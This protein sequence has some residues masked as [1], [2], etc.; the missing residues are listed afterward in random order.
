[1]AILVLLGCRPSAAP[2]ESPS[3]N[4]PAEPLPVA[5]APTPTPVD[6]SATSE[7]TTTPT[8]A[9]VAMAATIPET[10]FAAD[11]IVIGV[12]FD[13]APVTLFADD[14]KQ[15]RHAIA[16]TIARAG[17]PVVPVADLERIEA[18][19]GKGVLELEGGRR[20][21][22]ALTAA[23][24]E[25]RYFRGHRI[26][27]ANATCM[28]GCRLDVHVDTL[29]GKDS[30]LSWRHTGVRA[31]EAPRSWIAA[32]RALRVVD[33][34]RGFGSG[35]GVGG[36][37]D[38]QFMFPEPIGPWKHPLERESFS[39]VEHALAGCK[40]PNAGQL[41]FHDVRAS[42]D[43][44]GSIAHC[45]TELAV[46]PPLTAP[47]LAAC[48]CKVVRQVRL[49]RGPAGRRFRIEVLQRS[50]TF[51]IGPSAS[52][53][54]LQ[55]GTD[56]WVQRLNDSD[57]LVRCRASAPPD[58]SDRLTIGLP[59]AEDGSI[60]EIRIVGD[61]DTPGNGRLAECLVRELAGVDLPCRPPGLTELR[62]RLDLGVR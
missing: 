38:M 50:G 55:T 56:D 46:P 42:V 59:L 36:G 34:G 24:V 14:R 49:A 47:E 9:P 10:P 53:A 58:A 19:A 3:A 60:G 30:G 33:E 18:A 44:K 32:A 20:C 4:A 22:A 45:E 2:A 6:D 23:E 13:M 21:R 12:P 40:V 26:A 29:D 61:I 31:P 52:L 28:E 35:G 57:A 25:H 15:L 27:I 48:I 5:D 37:P 17:H 1:M 62:A 16:A 8:L 43:A 39:P 54:A 11:A 51:T 7:P 41:S